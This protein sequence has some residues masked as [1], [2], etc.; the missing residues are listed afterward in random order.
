[1]KLDLVA[2]V[3]AGIEGAQ[4]RRVLVG[5]APARGHRGRAPMLAELG[6]FLLRRG[7]AIGRH[8]LAPAAGRRANRS[9]SSNG[10]DWLKTSWVAKAGWLMAVPRNRDINGAR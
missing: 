4:L 6:Q 5:D 8:R 9:T 1:M 7:A 2:A 10:G 3:A